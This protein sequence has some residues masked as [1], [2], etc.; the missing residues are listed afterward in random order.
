MQAALPRVRKDDL[1]GE[2]YH[3]RKDKGVSGQKA[4]VTIARKYL[5]M[6]RTIPQTE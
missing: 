1:Y 4:L 3:R 2:E 5:P 6:P